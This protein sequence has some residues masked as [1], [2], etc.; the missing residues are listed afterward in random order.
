[1]DSD[2]ESMHG[3]CTRA[4]AQKMMEYITPA[5]RLCVE[6]GVW[7]G[8]SLLPVALAAHKDATIIGIDAWSIEASLD[9][10]NDKANEDWWSKINYDEMFEYTKNIMLKYNVPHVQLW[11]TKSILVVDKFQDESIDF[12]HQDSN[13]SEKVSCSEVEAYWNKVKH[14]GIWVFDDTDWSTTRPA[15]EMLESK[16]YSVLH[17]ATQWKIFVRN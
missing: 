16:G 3:W 1:M 4:K 6:F 12:L 10:V 17:D 5:T 13:H 15:Q 8:K 9:G 14:G 2:Y 7:G 11:R